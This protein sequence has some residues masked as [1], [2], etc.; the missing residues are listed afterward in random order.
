VLCVPKS[1]PIL[2]VVVSHAYYKFLNGRTAF[3]L[4]SGEFLK[5]I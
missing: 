1:L 5:V 4:M 3:R 2:L